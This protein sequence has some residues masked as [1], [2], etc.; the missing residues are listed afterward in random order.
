M[1]RTASKP[2]KGAEIASKEHPEPLALE[3]LREEIKCQVGNEAE[4]I[5]K[6][7]IARGEEGQL[8]AG[9]IL[10]RD[11]RVVPG[12]GTGTAAGKPGRR[13]SGEDTIA[14]VGTAGRAHLGIGSYQR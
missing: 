3:R 11:D 12:S 2:K 13:L 6:S 4:N 1:P 10:I 5:V 8:R 9:K 7:L 14:A